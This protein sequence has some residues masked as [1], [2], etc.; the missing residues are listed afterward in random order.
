ML[1]FV[2]RP[3]SRDSCV[4]AGHLQDFKVK[5]YSKLKSLSCAYGFLRSGTWYNVRVKVTRSEV[6]VL[7]DDVEV[8]VF[9][10][11]FEVN[12]RGGIMVA[13]GFKKKILFKDYRIFIK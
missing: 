10:S 6:K 12:G 5:K 11:L 9:K 8:A 13:S 1:L 4:Q 3:Y 2:S 7:I